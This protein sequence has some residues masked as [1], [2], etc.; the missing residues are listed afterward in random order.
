MADQLDQY[1]LPTNSSASLSRDDVRQI[2]LAE[3]QN[4]R[5]NVRVGAGNEVFVASSSGIQLGNGTF[6][7][8]PFNVDMQGNLVAS[9][10]T[11]NGSPL[12]NS[13]TFGSGVDGTGTISS[14]TSLSADTYY[15]SLHITS[16]ATLNANGWGLYVRTTTTIDAGCVLAFNGNNGT[17]ASGV[18]KGTGGAALTGHSLH[19]SL[20][21]L[22]GTNGGGRPGG[23]PG[24]ATNGTTVT[25]SYKASF[26]D[27]GGNGGA[28][29]GSG[30][31]TG[32]SPG[33]ITA[34]MKRPYAVSTA[35]NYLDLADGASVKYLRY[36]GHAGSSRGGFAGTDGGGTGGDGG[37]SGGN[38]SNAGCIVFASKNIVNNGSIQAVGGNG[39]NGA[40]GGNGSGG[41]NGGGGGGA[42]CGG[43]GGEIVLIYSSL[44]GTGTVTAAAGANGTPG[45]GGSGVSS[46]SA[47]GTPTGPSA[48]VVISLLV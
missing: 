26:T 43:A 8:A 46:G 2:V 38:G 42:G 36:N 29:S 4:L 11:I 19:G 20:A 30:T 16:G 25:N 48:G 1:T 47:G 18:T 7:S 28:S 15:D 45:S 33:S 5:S 40:N 35:T 41:G 6:A 12:D 39:G 13:Y 23:S 27:A 10:A 31:P 44:T 24:L 17:N 3:L 21:G 9:S 32:G 37:G 22:D 34:S 14:N